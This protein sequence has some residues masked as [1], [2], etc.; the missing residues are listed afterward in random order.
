MGTG[1]AMLKANLPSSRVAHEIP[2]F[3][4]KET[5]EV[6]EPEKKRFADT[7]G[8]NTQVLVCVSFSLVKRFCL[9]FKTHSS[10]AP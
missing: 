8:K 2:A 10:C 1:P 6:E 4:I 7:L 3:K 5:P 9:V